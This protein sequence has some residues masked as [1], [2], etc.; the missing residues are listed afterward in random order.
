MRR[1]IALIAAARAAADCITN[2]TNATADARVYALSRKFQ[3]PDVDVPMACAW[4][5]AWQRRV[6]HLHLSKMAG[7]EVLARAPAA[8]DV[9]AAA[10]AGCGAA[11]AAV[12]AVAVDT[13]ASTSA[14][15]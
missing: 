4:T 5:T 11:V 8:I 6:F 10:A 7:R 14:V 15:G 12:I 13:A 1:R 3:C 9:A 2:T